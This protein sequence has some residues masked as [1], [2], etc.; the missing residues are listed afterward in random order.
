MGCR[1]ILTECQ[2]ESRICYGVAA[3]S[4]DS[5][6]ACIMESYIDL[7]PDRGK[8]A[9]LVELCNAMELSLCQLPDVIEDFLVSL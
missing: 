1:Y 4:R 8:V 6:S 3:V 7:S 9:A 5:G 2:L